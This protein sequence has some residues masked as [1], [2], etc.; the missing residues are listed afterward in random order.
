MFQVNEILTTKYHKKVQSI[1]LMKK[2]FED[3]PI[4]IKKIGDLKSYEISY[5]KHGE[6]HD[7]S[8]ADELLDKLLKNV[9]I[10]FKSS[11]NVIIKRWFYN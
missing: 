10:R 1:M 4:E 11:G 9:K 7:F 3:K 2:P 5:N 6:V 8:N